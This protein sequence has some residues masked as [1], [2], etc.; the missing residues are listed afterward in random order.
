VSSKPAGTGR[1]V[2]LGPSRRQLLAAVVPGIGYGCFAAWLDP[3]GTA[4]AHVSKFGYGMVGI[5]VDA[6]SGTATNARQIRDA[7]LAMP[8]EAGPP[9]IVLVGY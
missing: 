4:A 5:E 9:R 7:I 8:M 2:D 1:P 3:P 6:L